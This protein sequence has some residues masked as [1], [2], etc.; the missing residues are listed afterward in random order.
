M[1]RCKRYSGLIKKI[2]GKIE[3]SS[4]A[5]SDLTISE[6]FYDFLGQPI[7][8]LKDVELPDQITAIV[9]QNDDNARHT[10]LTKLFLHVV[11]LF[12]KLNG[13]METERD[14]LLKSIYEHVEKNN[15]VFF[16]RQQWL[17]LEHEYNR[18]IFI[19]HF[20]TLKES[21]GANFDKFDIDTLN[22]ILFGPNPFSKFAC[23]I[24]NMLLNEDSDS[25]DKWKLILLDEKQLDDFEKD[26]LMCDGKWVVC[27][28]GEEID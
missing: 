20:R 8:S 24:C 18:L 12:Q 3:N 23:Q 25:N 15:S 22:D 9:K 7:I 13:R 17:N 11:R 14:K 27:P 19:D 1:V 2:Q 4:L 5:A 6:R 10:I 16:T 28:K 21:L 26:R